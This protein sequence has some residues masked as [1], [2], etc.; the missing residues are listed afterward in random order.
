MALMIGSGNGHT[1][2]TSSPRFS[3]LHTAAGRSPVFG[4][5]P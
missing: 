1:G 4:L 3:L 2:I 5:V